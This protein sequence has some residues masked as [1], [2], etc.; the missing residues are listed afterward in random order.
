MADTALGMYVWIAGFESMEP[1]VF[2]GT[3]IPM[4]TR[5]IRPIVHRLSAD[6]AQVQGDP[7]PKKNSISLQGRAPSVHIYH[8]P[9]KLFD[10]Y[11]V[12][13]RFLS[14][15]Y[16]LKEAEDWIRTSPGNE[17]SKD[18]KWTLLVYKLFDKDP[19]GM[20]IIITGKRNNEA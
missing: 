17:F 2:V 16:S 12:N 1:N 9:K 14:P 11:G 18:A 19:E 7:N 10:G 20:P 3:D 5:R 4:E 13:A 15:D 8:D 6:A